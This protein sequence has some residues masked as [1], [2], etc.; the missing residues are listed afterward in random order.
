M[1][2]LRLGHMGMRKVW[3]V[4]LIFWRGTSESSEEHTAGKNSGRSA[5]VDI[6]EGQ[7]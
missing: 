3:G 7:Q 4:R 6:R 1:T 2:Y 5:V